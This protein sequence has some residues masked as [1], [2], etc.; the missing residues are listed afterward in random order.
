M[1]KTVKFTPNSMKKLDAINSAKSLLQKRGVTFSHSGNRDFI[2]IKTLNGTI[3]YYPESGTYKHGVIHGYAENTESMIAYAARHVIAEPK[4]KNLKIVPDSNPFVDMGHNEVMKSMP[5]G[6][7]SAIDFSADD[8]PEEVEHKR[9]IFKKYALAKFR[10]QSVLRSDLAKGSKEYKKVVN[11]IKDIDY[12]NIRLR[13]KYPFLAK[14]GKDLQQF[15]VNCL[16][17][18][19]SHQVWQSYVERAEQMRVEYYLE[20]MGYKPVV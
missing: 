7:L 6:R 12:H 4:D 19:V 11:Y 20:E 18:D 15:I 9:D 8:T 14:A 2:N 16:R 3:S 1:I 17:A 10:L 5:I 13:E